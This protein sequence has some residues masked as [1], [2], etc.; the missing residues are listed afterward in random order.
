MSAI[1]SNQ[2]LTK[3]MLLHNAGGMNLIVP[4]GLGHHSGHPHKCCGLSL[5]LLSGIRGVIQTF[6]SLAW[7]LCCSTPP[8]EDCAVLTCQ[9]LD[10]LVVLSTAIDT[11]DSLLKQIGS[12]AGWLAVS[13]A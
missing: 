8:D 2:R 13:P 11:S 4:I 10:P 7:R 3:S 5:L 9:L 1:P 6:S 12:M